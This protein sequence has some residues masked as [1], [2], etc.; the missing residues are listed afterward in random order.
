VWIKIC[1]VTRPDAVAAALEAGADAIGFVFAE[2]VR[3]VS[4]E[5]AT[6]LAAPARGRMRCVAVTRHPSQQ[7]IDKIL[8]D[9]KPDVLQTDAGDL[10]GLQFPELLELLPVLRGEPDADVELPRRLLFEGLASGTGL[11]CDWTAARRVARRSQLVL[12][13]GL[14]P[15][16]VA[17]AIAE[18]APFGVD[19]SSGVESRPGMKS[20]LEIASFVSAARRAAESVTRQSPGV[21]TGA[22]AHEDPV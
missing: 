13:G 10:S 12:A 11:T 1:G 8:S 6:R 19:V 17:A 21:L 15:R 5:A 7:D 4:T 3:R 16:N 18:V 2:S 20:P 22:R 14:N 9:F